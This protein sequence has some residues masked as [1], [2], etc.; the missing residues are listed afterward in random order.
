MSKRVIFAACVAIVVLVAGMGF[1]ANIGIVPKQPQGFR[2]G[3]G[4]LLAW[5]A[6]KDELIAMLPPQPGD[7]AEQDE[8]TRCMTTQLKIAQQAAVAG[9]PYTPFVCEATVHHLVWC[10]NQQPAPDYPVTQAKIA[11]DEAKG[12]IDAAADGDGC[13]VST[14]ALPIPYYALVHIDVRRALLEFNRDRF[15]RIN[16]EF[17]SK[18]FNDIERSLS[19]SL[20]KPKKRVVGTAQNGFGAFFDTVDD[21]WQVGPVLVGLYKR[22]V[23][24]NQGVLVLT[25]IPLAKNAPERPVAPPPF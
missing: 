18:D 9:L 13:V 11:S 16:V 21:T 14:R 3:N 22:M 20:G 24:V 25:Y 12:I 7:S 10:S 19:E 6:S 2:F 1:C 4:R 15:F 17:A 8:Y 5:G 23:N